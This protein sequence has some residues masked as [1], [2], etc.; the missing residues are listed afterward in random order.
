MFV[1]LIP[2]KLIFLCLFLITIV[3]FIFIQ[4]CV[5]IN[6]KLKGLS[7]FFPNFKPSVMIR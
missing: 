1:I 5:Y 4:A 2:R 7:V 6:A 3:S